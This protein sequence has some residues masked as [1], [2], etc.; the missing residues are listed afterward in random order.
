MSRVIL[1]KRGLT[2][3]TMRQAVKNGL[4]A[5]AKAAEVDFKVTVRTWRNKPSF[6][7]SSPDAATRVVGTNNMIY[8]FLTRG[9][10]SYMIR[11]RNRK[12]L[13]FRGSYR[14]KTA[15]GVI[16][17]SSGGS[18]GAEIVARRVRH[19]GISARRF[20]EAIA[21]K[22]QQLLPASVQRAIDAVV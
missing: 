11:A 12:I 5:A 7:I 1:P 22:W 4:D 21:D 16:G 9:T 20:E 2:V 6:V 14:A 10:K 17:S 19:P 8:F 3:A 18:S 13:R 15:P